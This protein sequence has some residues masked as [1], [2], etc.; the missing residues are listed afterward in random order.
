MTVAA[1]EQIVADL[2]A[3]LRSGSLTSSEYGDY[4]K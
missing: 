1:R 3:G 4:S 2:V